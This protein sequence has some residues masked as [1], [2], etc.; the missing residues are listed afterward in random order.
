MTTIVF[1]HGANSSDK[2][3]NYIRA[4]L[5]KH[6]SVPLEYDTKTPLVEN[7][8][9]IKTAILAVSNDDI[10]IVS[11]SLGGVIAVSVAKEIPAIKKIV[12]MSTPF[13]GSQSA[14][15]LKWMFHNSQLL[16]DISTTNPVI[17]NLSKREDL[18]VL[19]FVSTLGASDFIKGEN[20]GVVTLES[21]KSL[22][23]P[24]YKE[25]ST[26]HFEILLDDS[27]VGDIKKFLF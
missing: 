23:G 5:P 8:E 26:N 1:L 25:V 9:Q 14:D 2:S 10:S 19:S 21:M 6:T 27:V 20:D 17:S 3:F 18:E 16:K 13:G 7:I 22:S 24:T 12:T 15:I 4:R 11:H